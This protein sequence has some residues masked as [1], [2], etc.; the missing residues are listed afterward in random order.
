[1]SKM[2]LPK[3]W[4]DC[5]KCVEIWL[6][7]RDKMRTILSGDGKSAEDESKTPSVPEVHIDAK[8]MQKLGKFLWEE[9]RAYIPRGQGRWFYELGNKLVACKFAHP[10]TNEKE[11]DD[12]VIT[13]PTKA[14]AFIRA[15]MH[16]FQ[17]EPRRF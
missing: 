9:C 14:K 13:C 16:A 2:R 6:E 5:E 8:Q 11:K 17:L 7:A 3:G 1:M 12:Y 4:T 15:N 10:F